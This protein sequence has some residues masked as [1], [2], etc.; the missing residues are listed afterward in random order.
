[1]SPSKSIACAL[2]T[3]TVPTAVF[4]STPSTE[5]PS[6]TGAQENTSLAAASNCENALACAALTSPSVARDFSPP[7]SVLRSASCAATSEM[8]AGNKKFWSAAKFAGAVY[9]LVNATG[10]TTS[11]KPTIAPSA[12]AGFDKSINPPSS[13]TLLSAS[14]GEPSIAKAVA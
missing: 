7:A 10:S 9:G 11:N 1:M 5:G 13:N 6:I 3:T 8:V 4:S 2:Y 14:E 12:A